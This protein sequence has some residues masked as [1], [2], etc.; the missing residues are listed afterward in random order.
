VEK[1]LNSQNTLK[2]KPIS[3]LPYDDYVVLYGLSNTANPMDCLPAYNTGF[4]H[5][6]HFEEHLSQFLI[7]IQVDMDWYVTITSKFLLLPESQPIER[8]NLLASLLIRY[9]N[10]VP[11]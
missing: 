2:A 11:N 10:N 9:F 7:D 3:E 5:L 1:E 6:K 4:Y 8:Y